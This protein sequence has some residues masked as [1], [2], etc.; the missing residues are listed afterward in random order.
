MIYLKTSSE[1]E[2]IRT[3][4][5]I[6][7]KTHAEVAK[8]I[9]PGITTKELD[10]VAYEYIKDNEAHPSFLNYNVGGHKYPA[11]LCISVN[12]VVVHGIPN[13]Y[14]LKD[15]DIISIDCGVYKNGFH[16]DSAYTYAVGNVKEETLQLLRVTK[17]SLY[18]GISQAVAGKRI[19]DIGFAIQ[20]YCEKAG[21]TVV[22]ELVGHGVGKSLHEGPEVANYGR[23]GDGPKLKE[24]MVI[25]IEPMINLGKRTI[26]QENDYWTIRTQDH[27]PS[28]HFEHTVA[29]SKDQAGILTTF[30]YIEEVLRSNEY[31]A[32]I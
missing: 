25:A 15:G 21:F 3:N 26:H 12:D 2:I 32:E 30:E 20:S 14:E 17:E 16:A 9:K 13:N 11:S 18:L 22:R 5:V 29:V 19:G 23:R 31:L 1:L 7:G 4:G 27:K 6:L 28:A 10:K 8:V 24:G